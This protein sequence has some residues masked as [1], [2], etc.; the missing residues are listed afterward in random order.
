MNS[1]YLMPLSVIG[2]LLV[3]GVR[4]CSYYNKATTL[5]E[6]VKKAWSEVEN[7]YQR[8]FDLIDNLVSTVKG[9]ADFEQKTLTDVIEARAKATS[10]QIDPTNVTPEQLQQFEQNQAGL[11]SALSRLMVVSENYPNLKANEN[12]LKLQDE[13]SGTENRVAVARKNFN[14]SVSTFN[15]SIRRFPMV[16]FAG[17]FGFS[18]KGYFQ[19]TEGAA[20]APK[21]QF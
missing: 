19:S 5:D 3:L 20:K 1:K 8:R 2:I 15:T 17:M 16:L 13:I 7:Q 4:T 10:I 6:G 9:Y 21:V 12:F 14:E 18:Q 11:N